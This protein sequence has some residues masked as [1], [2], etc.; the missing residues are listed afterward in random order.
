MGINEPGQF[1]HL[2]DAD[3]ENIE[4]SPPAKRS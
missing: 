4:W 3:G 2:D 1:I